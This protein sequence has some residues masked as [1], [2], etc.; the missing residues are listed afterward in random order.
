MFAFLNYQ[1]IGAQKHCW[2]AVGKEITKENKGDFWLA[3]HGANTWGYDKV[4]LTKRQQWVKDNSD[5]IVACGK[6]PIANLQWTD[7]DS[8]YQFLAFVMRGSFMEQGDGF[9]LTFCR[10][11]AVAMDCNC[12]H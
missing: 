5:W 2:V 4:S 8:P 10:L 12:T 7:A 11:M 6:G 9:S 1:S 3:V